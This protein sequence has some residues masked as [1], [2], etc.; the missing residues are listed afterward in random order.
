MEFIHYLIN[1]LEMMIVIFF[2]I[3]L[4]Y[5]YTM[6]KGKESFWSSSSSSFSFDSQSIPILKKQ[7]NHQKNMTEIS[8]VNDWNQPWVFS[9]WKSLPTNA[10]E[11]KK[12]WLLGPSSSGKT[13]LLEFMGISQ[14]HAD[15]IE[16]TVGEEFLIDSNWP[17]TIFV[18]TQGLYQLKGKYETDICEQIII[19][20]AYQCADAIILVIPKLQRH[21]AEMIY[22][23]VERVRNSRR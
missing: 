5:S 3:P 19:D 2:I 4:L 12:V 13:T 23:M 7:R 8:N 18:N 14:A 17:N 16:T 15:N 10:T 6:K 1:F 21:D 11:C 20:H 22:E 9:H